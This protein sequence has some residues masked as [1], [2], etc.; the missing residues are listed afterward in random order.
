MTQRF[1]AIAILFSS[2]V[3]FF[4]ASY[5]PKVRG[6]LL[7]IGF[8]VGVTGIFASYSNLLPQIREKVP[9]SLKIDMKS[10][11]LMREVLDQG[12]QIADA[13]D[14]RIKAQILPEFALA[15]A[16]AGDLAGARTI[17]NGAVDEV[18]ALKD[19]NPD[20]AIRDIDGYLGSWSVLA[21]LRIASAQ[22]EIGDI[23]ARAITIERAYQLAERL[24][25]NVSKAFS[26]QWVAVAQV[27]A[28]D[29]RG[30]D[31][32]IQRA[33]QVADMVTT[34]N[35]FYPKFFKNHF[36]MKI[37]EA[38]IEVG[39]R[40]SARA[41][42]AQALQ[43]AK[44]YTDERVFL[45]IAI[46]QAKLGDVQGALATTLQNRLTIS[47]SGQVAKALSDAGQRVDAANVFQKAVEIAQ[48][49]N[50]L[51]ALD[52]NRIA[53]AKVQIGDIQG[54]I[55]A[56]KQ[57]ETLAVTHDHTFETVVGDPYFLGKLSAA[58][59]KAGDV[60]GALQTFNVIPKGT[61]ESYDPFTRAAFEFPVLRAVAAAQVKAGDIK[62]ALVWA[63]NRK[64]IDESAYALL[65]VA[66]GLLS[67]K[68][69][70][71]S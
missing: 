51:D 9:P 37:A 32:T 52:W 49:T 68:S 3:F 1:L 43:R 31:A 39:N 58:Q 63:Q 42:I 34:D 6:H 22:G 13:F 71:Q 47:D 62:G 18:W 17:L 57:A 35:Y 30:A 41:A 24:Q 21:L 38:H 15:Q 20:Y 50:T 60:R 10:E 61:G 19:E 55:E 16:K 46:A 8:F 14:I 65:G 27:K 59:A 44:G 33:F 2:F 45:D 40:A 12:R 28:E 67:Q 4:I 66:D 54:A 64:W 5:F 48:S 69:S 36:A 23:T 11:N 53:M 25:N 7:I 29:V 56:Q 70:Q 26:L